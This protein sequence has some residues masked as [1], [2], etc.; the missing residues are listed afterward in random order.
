[1]MLEKAQEA[2]R[3]AE[4]RHEEGSSGGEMDLQRE[5]GN[6]NPSK[7]KRKAEGQ[8]E[9]FPGGKL[10]SEELNLGDQTRKTPDSDAAV[11]RKRRNQTPAYPR[12]IKVSTMFF[13]VSG[14][15]R[16]VNKIFGNWSKVSF[17]I[18]LPVC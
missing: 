13:S 5:S 11:V 8:T 4:G 2:Q 15:V 9:A 12:K 17:L 7:G 10:P 14:L 18:N 3:K 16:Y 6:K 1:M